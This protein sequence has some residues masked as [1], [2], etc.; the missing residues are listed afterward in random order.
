MVERDDLAG[1]LQQLTSEG[2]LDSGGHF[3]LDSR[4]AWDKSRELR[5]S[6]P[7][8]YLRCLYR[9]A[10]LGEATRVEFYVDSD[11]TILSFDGPALTESQLRYLVASLYVEETS[12]CSRKLQQLA[13][14]LHGAWSQGYAW[15]EVHSSQAGFRY[16]P[17]RPDPE[18]VPRRNEK[19][20]IHLKRPFGARVIHRY[21][22]HKFPEDQVLFAGLGWSDVTT[23]Y[24]GRE[25]ARNR[26]RQSQ[27]RLDVGL[28]E[29]LRLITW[30]PARTLE[31]PGCPQDL[32]LVFDLM[33]RNTVGKFRLLVADVEV[34]RE[35]SLERCRGMNAVVAVGPM[36]LDASQILAVENE[37]FRELKIFLERAWTEGVLQSNRSARGRRQHRN[38]LLDIPSDSPAYDEARS[39]FYTDDQ[40]RPKKPAPEPAPSCTRTLRVFQVEFSSAHRVEQSL[41]LPIV[42]RLRESLCFQREARQIL[43]S[44]QGQD[45]ETFRMGDLVV[46]RA[47]EEN[48]RIYLRLDF[49][50]RELDFWQ[51]VTP[52]SRDTVRAIVE[53]LLKTTQVPHSCE[54]SA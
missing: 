33:T 49:G 31:I 21:L 27:F 11:D 12:W 6:D 28:P 53:R 24:N 51:P 7:G 2:L 4:K 8:Q 19:N 13:L 1:L 36:L 48:D 15:A 41:Y 44:R 46:M 45:P 37:D 29:S 26:C 22:T 34:P 40:E 23:T 50:L 20:G 38:L 43:L 39:L 52:E 25:L 42:S 9:G 30:E 14:G 10:V 18:M 35:Y 17:D 32:S 16:Y 47:W 3:T 5:F 54:W